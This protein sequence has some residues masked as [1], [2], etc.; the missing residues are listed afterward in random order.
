M[1]VNVG[2]KFRKKLVTV[3]ER[4]G[5]PVFRYR[6]AYTDSSSVRHNESKISVKVLD[7]DTLS[8]MF[9]DIHSFFDVGGANQNDPGLIELIYAAESSTPGTETH[10]KK[11][12]IDEGDE[13]HFGGWSYEVQRQKPLPISGVN[14]FRH[15][16]ATRLRQL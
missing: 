11:A 8:T 1:P 2:E 4:F 13:L 14:C 7:V 5:N 3:L 6:P 16:T 15:I 9:K 10:Y 12:T